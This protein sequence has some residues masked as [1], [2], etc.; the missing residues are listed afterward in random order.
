[1]LLS[2]KTHLN[3]SQSYSQRYSYAFSE[4]YLAF[5][6][7]MSNDMRSVILVSTFAEEGTIRGFE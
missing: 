4:W 3:C 7:G 1:M 6:N 2:S 5:E